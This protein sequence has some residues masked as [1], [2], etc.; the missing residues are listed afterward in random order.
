ML[1]LWS[2]GFSQSADNVVAQIQAELQSHDSTRAL[3]LVHAALQ[4]SPGDPRLWT[5][6]GAIYSAQGNKKNALDS[7]HHALKIAPN[8]IPALHGAAQIEYEAS[9]VAAIPL[10]QHLLRLQPQDAT[11]HGM[12]AI[13]AYQ[14]GDCQLATAHFEKAGALFDSQL[15]GLH[16]YATCLMRLKEFDRAAQALQ[17]A[18]LLSPN[19]SRERQVLAAVQLRGGQPQ[20]ALSTLGPL[21]QA[22]PDSQT[23]ELAATAQEDARNT[24][25]AVKLLQQAILL[26]PHNVNLYVDFALMSAAHQSN[27]VGINV[28]S[29]GITQEPN[30]SALYLARGVLYAQLDQYDKAQADFEKANDLDPSQSL[31]TAAQGL[32]A[33]QKN[34]LDQALASVQERLA[35]RPNDPALLY[36]QG[37]I[38]AQKGFGPPSPEFA[39]AMR[40]AKKAVSLQPTLGPAHDVLAKLYLRSGDYRAA[41]QECRL[42]LKIDSTD[43]SAV[44]RLIQ[45]LRKEGDNQETSELVKRLAKLRRESAREES[46]RNRFRLADDSQP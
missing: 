8:A 21:L 20:Q 40:S 30:A 43:Q 29:D 10:L 45:A 25:E 3:E 12:L 15:E 46:E 41:A 1:L 39:T 7:F 33:M 26:D 31:S 14:R 27:D 28:V 35:R 6:Q 19:D 4:K 16:A 5:L 13:V 32:A 9:S 22:K 36:L 34:D 38:L 2:S 42:A 11:S 44:Y 24:P 37:D 18:L 23:L 17:R